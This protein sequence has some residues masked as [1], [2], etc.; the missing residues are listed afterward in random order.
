MDLYTCLVPSFGDILETKVNE[1][2]FLQS[3][4]RLPWEVR[5]RGGREESMRIM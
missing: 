4:R 3:K 5:G 2:G 1:L